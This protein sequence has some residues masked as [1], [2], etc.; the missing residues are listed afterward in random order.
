MKPCV[1]FPR[2][3]CRSFLSGACLIGLIALVFSIQACRSPNRARHAVK[4]PRDPSLMTVTAYC[5]CGKCCGWK[6]NFF[7]FGEP[8]YAYGKMKGKPKKVGLT[9][10]GKK[11]RKG[12]IAADPRL[13]PLGTHLYV[14][15]YGVGTVEDIGGAIKGRH[16]DVW[17]P[18]HAQAKA[19][20]VRRLKVE[21][22]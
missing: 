12:T 6:R 3:R 22:R 4:E 1:R 17:F 8:V 15:G 11:A 18:S 16:I 21:R 10:S 7:G 5:N 19:W 9:A 20:G 14:P 2:R 13:F